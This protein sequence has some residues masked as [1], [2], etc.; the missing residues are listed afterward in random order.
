MNDGTAAIIGTRLRRAEMVCSV[1][2]MLLLVEEF[3]DG[4]WE[5]D[6]GFLKDGVIEA[7]S[8][9]SKTFECCSGPRRQLFPDHTCGS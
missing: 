5:I 8:Y 9:K 6:M 3:L 4:V 2:Y 1:K 7:A